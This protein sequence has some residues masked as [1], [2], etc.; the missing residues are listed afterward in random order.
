MIS[1]H[2]AQLA[3][4]RVFSVLVQATEGESTRGFHFPPIN[5]LLRWKDITP[6]IN[7]VVLIS[8]AAALIGTVLFLIAANRDHKTAPKGARN[9]AEIAVEFIEKNIIMETMGRSGLGWTPFLLTMFIFIY[10][11]NV[12]GIIPFIQMPATARMGIPAFMALL[13]WVV[14][15]ATGIKNQGPIGYFKNVLFP[16]GVP[17]AL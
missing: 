17:K 12:P 5:T 15:N 3:S 9:L 6:G 10:I 11:C 4:A 8:I 2:I 7:K 14:Y 13:V 16:P 1:T